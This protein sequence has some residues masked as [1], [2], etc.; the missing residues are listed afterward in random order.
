MESHERWRK[1]LTWTPLRILSRRSDGSLVAKSN[2]SL[3]FSGGTCLGTI[4]PG[5][6]WH[7]SRNGGTSANLTRILSAEYMWKTRS[8]Y[9]DT[10]HVREPKWMVVPFLEVIS[11]GHRAALTKSK[12]DGAC[13]GSTEFLN[14]TRGWHR[15][16]LSERTCQ[17]W[18]L[19]VWDV[20]G[21]TDLQVWEHWDDFA[22]GIQG[23]LISLHSRPV[24]N[25]WTLKRWL[26]VLMTTLSPAEKPV[27][28]TKI[29][30]EQNIQ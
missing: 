26:R 13:T 7:S 23:R 12:S 10:K 27:R 17:W 9:L 8:M 2:T 20:H 22:W 15:Q 1:I 18:T 19:R 5:G 28:N 4:C 30:E 11:N 29:W 6:T 24:K 3:V 16:S 14:D 21:Q 25:E